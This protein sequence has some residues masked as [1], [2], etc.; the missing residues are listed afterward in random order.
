MHHI[1]TRMY[2]NVPIKVYFDNSQARKKMNANVYVNSNV[3][4]SV[5]AGYTLISTSRLY[6]TS[7][8]FSCDVYPRPLILDH[9][10]ALYLISAPNICANDNM[11]SCDVYPTPFRN[12]ATLLP[13]QSSLNNPVCLNPQA[14]TITSQ[15]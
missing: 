15:R 9:H 7:G 4:V 1:E 13:K 14:Y 12:L 2:W 6:V 3:D 10:S 8:A 5:Y 11:Q